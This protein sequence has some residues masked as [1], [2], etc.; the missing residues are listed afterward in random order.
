MK[1]VTLAIILLMAVQSYA[2]KVEVVNVNTVRKT[3]TGTAI[4]GQTMGSTTDAPLLNISFLLEPT[5]GP[6]LASCLQA[7]N[8]A[9]AHNDLMLQVEGAVSYKEE[10]DTWK[11]AKFTRIDSCTLKKRSQPE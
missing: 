9:I 2:Y 11:N 4:W 7:A 5:S 1:L 6:L 10:T 8:Q 3:K